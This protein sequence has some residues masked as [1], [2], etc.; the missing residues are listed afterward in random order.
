MATVEKSDGE[1]G[2][3]CMIPLRWI[4]ERSGVERN[5]CTVAV[6][7]DKYCSKE[8]AGQ[9]IT[10]TQSLGNFGVL[11]FIYLFFFYYLFEFCFQEWMCYILICPIFSVLTCL[12]YTYNSV[13]SKENGLTES[14]H[15]PQS[16]TN[17][18]SLSHHPNGI[19]LIRSDSL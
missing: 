15:N 16:S 9:F 3:G 4:K 13:C 11:L 6:P 5:K 8:T 12:N 19:A 1:D 10:K 14:L 7:S 2:E 17:R 18:L